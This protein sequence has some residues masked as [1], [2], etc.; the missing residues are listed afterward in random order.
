M[1][2]LVV[3]FTRQYDYKSC[4]YKLN[5]FYNKLMIIL[6]SAKNTLWT[7]THVN[8]QINLIEITKLIEKIMDTFHIKS[9]CLR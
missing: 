9:S 7:V 2:C 3:V 6:V 5:P 8:A 4:L 1:N